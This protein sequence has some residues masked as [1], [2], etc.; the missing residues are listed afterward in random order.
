MHPV[1]RAAVPVVPESSTGRPQQLR[2]RRECVFFFFLSAFVPFGA[3]GA[4]AL[5]P[6]KGSAVRAGQSNAC[7]VWQYGG[8]MFCAA[9]ACG[10]ITL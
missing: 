7:S 10:R 2:S 8:N 5:W 3:M 6:R 4:C 1:G 9:R